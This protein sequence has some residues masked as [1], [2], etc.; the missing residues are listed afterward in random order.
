[1]RNIGKLVSLALLVA[2]APLLATCNKA[3]QEQP[4]SYVSPNEAWSRLHRTLWPTQYGEPIPLPVARSTTATHDAIDDGAA[5][6]GYLEGPKKEHTAAD[7][8]ERSAQRRRSRAE[9]H[10][11][12]TRHRREA[13]QHGPG[14]AQHRKARDDRRGRTAVLDVQRSR[15]DAAQVAQIAD[16]GIGLHRTLWPTPYVQVIPVPVAMLIPQAA[17][18]QPTPAPPT[19]APSFDLKGPRKERVA[20]RSDRTATAS[21]STNS[22]VGNNLG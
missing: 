10:P 7:A 3:E 21:I 12:S 14:R 20:E 18:T 22:E 1:M 17:P 8:R 15:A 13:V 2:V 5:N 6:P 16:R 11:A 19:P 9:H 4:K